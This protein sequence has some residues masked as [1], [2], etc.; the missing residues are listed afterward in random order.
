MLSHL[1]LEPAQLTPAEATR[2]RQTYRIQPELGDCTRL[3]DVNVRRLRSLVAVEEE[4][5]PSLGQATV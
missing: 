1:S 3:L 4:W 2:R 5:L